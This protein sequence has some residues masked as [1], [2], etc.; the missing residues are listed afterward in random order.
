MHIVDDLP[1]GSRD[2]VVDVLGR[3]C[4]L[5]VQPVR[6]TL[7]ET[8]WLA[9]FDAVYPLA[10]AVGVQRTVDQPVRTIENNVLETCRVLE[11]A[12]HQLPLL[13]TTTS[14]VYGNSDRIPFR[15]DDDVTYGATPYTR[16]SYAMSKAL[17]EQLADRVRAVAGSDSPKRFVSHDEAYGVPV[18]D[19]PRRVPDLTRVREAIGFRASY[20]L[21]DTLEELVRLAEREGPAE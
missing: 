2:N 12:A 8:G 9:G 21:D 4:T 20:R 19:M 7:A 1:T 14:E 6:N 15:E 10:A 13:L 18:D 11:A 3:R 17:D 5:Q 16:W